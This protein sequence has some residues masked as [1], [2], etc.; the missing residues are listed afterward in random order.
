LFEEALR[1]EPTMLSSWFQLTYIDLERGAVATA[2]ERVAV[3]RAL[4]EDGV[5]PTRLGQIGNILGRLGQ[6]DEARAVLAALRKR[7]ETEFVPRTALGLALIGLGDTEHALDELERGCD[8][9][10]T[11]LV[12]LKILPIFDPLRGHPRFERLVQRMHFP[13]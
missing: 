1:L 4:F 6:G 8:Q 2:A 11:F 12:W 5:S 3:M 10:D 13:D 7:S 9:R